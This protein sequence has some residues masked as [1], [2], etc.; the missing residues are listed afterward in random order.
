MPWKTDSWLNDGSCY[1]CKPEFWGMP[2][3]M[4]TVSRVCLC[5]PSTLGDSAAQLAG[6]KMA[7]H[8]QINPAVPQTCGLAC[9]AQAK[10][11]SNFTLQI[12]DLPIA[13]GSDKARQGD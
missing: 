3:S 6:Y 11:S 9:P 12:C 5:F 7:V 4:A 10:G 1:R 13:Q 2:A 8:V